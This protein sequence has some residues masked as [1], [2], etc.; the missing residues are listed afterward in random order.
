MRARKNALG[1][2]F[3]C[4]CTSVLRGYSD[5]WAAVTQDRLLNNGTK[6]RILNALAQQPKTIARLAAELELSQPAVHTHITELLQSEL[7]REARDWEKRHPAEK[8]YEPNFPVIRAA[9]RAA[10]QPICEAA[11]EQMATIFEGRQEQLRRALKKTGLS[12]Q[13]W[14]FPDIAQFCYA[15]AQRGA[16]TL[17]ERRGVLP[18][19]KKHRNGSEW[20]FWAEEPVSKTEK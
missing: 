2:H 3:P 17:L 11:A 8:Y 6:E 10:F 20:V 12:E 16:R 18:R 7:L 15:S 14:D 5:P 9:Y 19:R 13:G 1:L 4:E